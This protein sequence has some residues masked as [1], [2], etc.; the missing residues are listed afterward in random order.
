MKEVSREGRAL[1]VRLEQEGAAA[2]WGDEV[3]ARLL[4]VLVEAGVPVCAFGH[5][6]RNLEDAF[7]RVTR[8]RVA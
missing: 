3:A 1:R 6:E 2:A 5:R 4:R 7:M 8:G